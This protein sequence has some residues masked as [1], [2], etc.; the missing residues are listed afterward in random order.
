VDLVRE[1]K[2]PPEEFVTHSLMRPYV[3]AM[4]Y[5]LFDQGIQYEGHSQNVLVEMDV[6]GRLTGRLVLRDFSDSTVNIALRVARGKALPLFPSAFLPRRT[7]FF[8][9]TIAADFNVE[10]RWRTFRGFDTVKRYGLL[11]FVWSINTSMARYVDGYDARQVEREY[12]DLWRQAAV[13]YLKLKPMFRGKGIATDETIAC[14]LS[15]VDWTA[16]GATRSTLP[17]AAQPLRI[18]GRMR[19]RGGPV[20]DRLECPWGDLFMSEGMPGFFRPRY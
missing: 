1:A 14:F 12:L 11:G 13:D 5:L 10:K 3:K 6:R 9:S 2:R 16:M 17:D 19:R 8:I 18:E 15:R 4:A 20:Y 7:P